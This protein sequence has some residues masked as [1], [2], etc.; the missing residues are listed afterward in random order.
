MEYLRIVVVAAVLSS[1]VFLPG[2]EPVAAS[3]AAQTVNWLRP[4]DGPYPILHAGEDISIYVSIS[5]QRVY[6][7]SGLKVIY[8]MLASTG[9]DDANDDATPQG[10][11]HIQ[12][13]RGRF[14]YS[15]SEHEGAMYWV[16]WLHHGE[17]LFH[18]VPTDRSG[19]II[20]QEAM[21]LG[22]EASHGCVRLPV[23][24]AKWIFEHVPFGTQV[25]IGN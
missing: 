13:E 16:S 3:P 23:P 22:H 4:S 5:R 12:K 18:S 25:M 8:T 14:F 20:E 2:I 10:I 21:K 24:D 6:I 17:Y 19:R 11:F 15:P 9:I 1:V 7:M